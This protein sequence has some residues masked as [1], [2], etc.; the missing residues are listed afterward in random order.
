MSYK[1]EQ[2][3]RCRRMLCRKAAARAARTAK[4][5]ATRLRR[6][7]ER[8][9]PED[10]PALFRRGYLGD[11]ARANAQLARREA[12]RGHRL[13][14]DIDAAIAESIAEVDRLERAL[15][16]YTDLLADLGGLL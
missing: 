12:M 7:A 10:A 5:A 9:D 15:E 11:L 14:A 2:I 16:Y 1:P 8:V 6:R 4:K 13:P 3:S